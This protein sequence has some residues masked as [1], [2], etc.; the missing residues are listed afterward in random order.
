MDLKEVGH[1]VVE[2]INLAQSWFH[3]RLL[4]MRGCTLGC[5]KGG[6]LL[7]VWMINSFPGK[8]LHHRISLQKI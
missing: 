2:W 7:T 3:G 8:I 6:N 5:I 4:W 1:K